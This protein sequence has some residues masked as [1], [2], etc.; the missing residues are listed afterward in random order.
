MNKDS[1]ARLAEASAAEAMAANGM[2]EAAQAHAANPA[3]TG[4]EINNME[5]DNM[6]AMEAAGPSVTEKPTNG[7]VHLDLDLEDDDLNQPPE[8]SYRRQVFS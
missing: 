1:M 4:A 2:W 3:Q 5:A 7:S 6:E 8:V